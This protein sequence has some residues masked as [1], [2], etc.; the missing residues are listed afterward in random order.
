MSKDTAPQLSPEAAALR[1]E[2]N[3]RWRQRNKDKIR[4]YNA[5]F[6]ARKAE[7]FRAARAAEK[8]EVTHE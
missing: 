8:E 5:A 3:R 4:E 7:E 2:Y 6:W 1:R